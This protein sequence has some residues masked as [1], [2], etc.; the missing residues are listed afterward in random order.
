MKIEYYPDTDTLYISLSDEPGADAE[1]VAL[2]IVI[3]VDAAGR[4]VGI[5]IEPASTVT[6]AKKLQTNMAVSSVS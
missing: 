1:E 5:E 3:D 4:P 2:G 6:D